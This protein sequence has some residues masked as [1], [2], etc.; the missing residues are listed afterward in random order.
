MDVR[1]QV[2]SLNDERLRVF[3]QQEKLMEETRGR[4][5]SEEE[6]TTLTRM[7][8][9]I[10]RIDAEIRDMVNRDTRER[11]AGA[12]REA[13]AGLFGADGDRKLDKVQQNENDQLRAWL[14][15][16]DQYRKAHPFEINIEGARRQRQLL[17]Q[18]YT[19]QEIRALAWDTGSVA[20]GVPTLVASSLYE[21]LEA[22]TVMMR[23]PT[24]KFPTSNGDSIKLPKTNAH[25]IATQVSGQGTTLAGT[26]PTFLSATLDAF[27]YAEL[28]IVANEVLT[29]VVFPIAEFVGRDIGRALGRAI[30]QD[31]TI[32]SGSG[33]PNGIMTAVAGAGTIATGGS[34]ITPTAEKLIDLQYSV[35]DAYRAGGNAGWLMRDSTAGTLRKLRDN[36]LAAGTSG[37]FLWEPSLTNGL[38][39]GVPDRLFGFPVYTGAYVASLGSNNKIIGFGDFSAYYI[40][41]VGNIL[42][43]SDGSRYFDTDQTGFRG[44]WR[45]DGE[46]VDTTAFNVMKMNP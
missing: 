1:A 33:A 30:D 5:R 25:A 15:G 46:L 40:R 31:L 12:L 41:T 19:P 43:D 44:K 2:I 37:A 45:I 38:V 18:G 4:E 42:L 26:D 3:D 16:D 20:S 27:K 11:E 17:R 9:D 28:V 8:A 6:K 29:D 13:N 14:S 24:T 22:F 23:A 21:T 32:G 7:D 34:L 39:N 10:D 36:A 35:A